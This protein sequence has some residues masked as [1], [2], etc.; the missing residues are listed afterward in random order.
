MGTDVEIVHE[1]NCVLLYTAVS[2]CK[3]NAGFVKFMLI[4]FKQKTLSLNAVSNNRDKAPIKGSIII[5]SW[6]FRLYVH[7]RGAIMNAMKIYF[8]YK[9]LL[10]SL[11]KFTVR[12]RKK[13]MIVRHENNI[14]MKL[15]I[16]I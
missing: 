5:L 11:V 9:Q 15:T 6:I 7:R 8:D 16:H 1:I 12:E 2:K 14:H 13:V 10:M 4:Y 3:M